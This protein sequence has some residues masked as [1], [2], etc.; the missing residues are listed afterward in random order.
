MT[1][2]TEPPAL[3]ADSFAICPDCGSHVNCGMIGLPNLK[4]RQHGMKVCKTAQQKQDKD[5]K[6]KKDR[7]ILNFLRPKAAIV[8]STVHGPPPVHSFKLV[9]QSASNT[10][11]VAASTT[12]EQGKAVSNS[13][14]KSVSVT[15]SNSFIEMLRDLVK[16]LPASVPEASKFD[17]LAVFGG[18][19]KEFDDPSLEADELWESSLNGVLKSTLGWGMEGNMD[20]IICHGRWGLDGLVDFA[21]YFVEE[22][23]VSGGLFEGKL[24][25]LV[26]ALKTRSDPVEHYQT[27]YS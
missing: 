27:N 23:G 22:C 5:A 20:E 3:D 14:S 25:N 24:T 16:N 15:I 18:N 1:I 9:P 12:S 13:S 21:T 10:S 11:P 19:P 26:A 6:E 2:E 17:R 7:T 8:P 4:E